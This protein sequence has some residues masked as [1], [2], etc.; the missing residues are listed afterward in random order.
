MLAKQYLQGIRELLLEIEQGQLVVIDEAAQ[1]IAQKVANGAVVHLFDN[2][3]LLS[4]ETVT[5]AGGLMIM[6]P[7]SFTITTNNPARERPG[8][9]STKRR[10]FPQEGEKLL[11]YLLDQSNLTSGDVL[12]INSVSGKNVIPVELALEAKRRGVYVIAITSITYSKTLKSLHSSG[13]RLFEVADLVIDNC[14]VV[15]DALL[16]VEGLEAKIC[17]SSGVT[18]AVII[19]MLT[20]QLVTHL[21]KLGI[22]PSVYKSINLEGAI[23]YN[24][25]QKERY[26]E[27]GY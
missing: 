23:D 14:G 17:P 4:H 8:V 7:I 12:I 20:A 11:K 16:E 21:L 9:N 25:K 22:T 19:W 1:L 5:R 18:A 13:K 24:H 6:T 27:K 3:H 10:L 2:G 15:G 26:L